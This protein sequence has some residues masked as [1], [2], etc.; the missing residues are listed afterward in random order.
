MP[1]IPKSSVGASLGSRVQTQRAFL[2]QTDPKL[3][4]MVNTSTSPRAI[5]ASVGEYLIPDT[6][7]S[8]TTDQFFATRVRTRLSGGRWAAIAPIFMGSYFVNQRSPIGVTSVPPYT[9][10]FTLELANGTQ[11]SDYAS[12][13]TGGTLVAGT[14][15]G[16]TDGIV[17]GGDI[18]VGDFIYA[19]SVGLQHFIW[20]D[21]NLL[22]WIRVAYAKSSAADIL[23]AITQTE[24]NFPNNSH[25][26]TCT[27]YT[28]AKALIATS[29]INSYN[30]G[31]N[32]WGASDSQ[33]LPSCIGFIGIG[34][35]GQKAV[36]FFGTS[37]LDGDG[38]SGFMQ[39]GVN[40]SNN[41]P[42]NYNL[43]G[44]P[45]AWA[46]HLSRSTAVLNLGVGASAMWRDW[47][48]NATDL[49]W[50]TNESRTLARY[51]FAKIASWFDVCVAHD[52]H[53]DGFSSSTYSEVL[54]NF[55]DVIRE[56]NP[57]LKLI[58][59]RVP[60][61]YIDISGSTVAYD[62]S[63]DV[64]W[65]TQ[66]QM[67]VNGYWDR[68]ISVR[69]SGDNKFPDLGIQ[70][71]STTTALGTAT[72][73]VDSGATWLQNQ[74]VNSWVKIGGVKKLISSNTRTQLTFGA[75]GSAIVTGTPYTIEG[76]CSH[77]GL[78]P[79]TV[80]QFRMG[81]NFDTAIQAVITI[82]KFVRT[83]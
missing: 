64:R 37:I 11:T 13:N 40:P 55:T 71:S 81:D 31:N 22:P 6:G 72:S 57:S 32:F 33:T 69:E 15:N 82:P 27:S 20:T 70:V 56:S 45:C 19:N 29:G 68:A 36:V 54:K 34:L 30:A 83:A 58:S 28:I 73:L 1:A 8:Q 2:N 7:S 39:G 25:Y 62:S 24:F 16:A 18:V 77:D 59:C 4:P 38:S 23:G 52:V 42:A 60:N 44:Y 35:D 79:S 78:H 76:N 67:V 46:Q 48:N 63:L 50:S 17:R 65:A 74:W 66:D 9:C 12:P 47:S 14:F 53:N 41:V 3:A 51:C 49:S 61:G 5:W 26:A 43:M 10:S 80:G 75:Y 21:R